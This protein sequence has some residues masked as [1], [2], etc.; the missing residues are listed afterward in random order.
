MGKAITFTLAFILPLLL[1]TNIAL[2]ADYR[3]IVKTGG[4]DSAGTDANVYITLIGSLGSSGERQLDSVKDDFERHSVGTYSIHTYDTLGDLYY[5]RIRH[6]NTEKKP[7]W[8]LDYITVHEE[9]TDRM[10]Y[11]PCNRWL[12]VDEDDHLIDRY[13]DGY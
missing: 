1:G 11:L 2:S 5:V 4:V 7:G 12:A 3:I 8:F 10:W 13:L 6:D 9:F